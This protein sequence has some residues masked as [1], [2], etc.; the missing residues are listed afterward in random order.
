MLNTILLLIIGFVF[1]IKSADALVDGASLLAKHFGVSNL[2]IGLT[3]VAFGTSLPE[4][5]VNIS[6]SL[7]NNSSI[8]ISNIMGSNIINI[9]LILGLSAL[10]FPLK[11]QNS[12]IWKEIPLCLL[13]VFVIIVMANDQLF[14]LLPMGI[15]GS[16][17]I[18]L[19]CF[20]AVFLYY[21]L[22]MGAAKSAEENLPENISLRKSLALILIG[23]VGLPLGA[24]L[25]L[26]S[27]V[28]LATILHVSQTIIGLTI[29]ALGTSLPELFTSVS[30]ALKRNS[31]IAVGNIVGSNLF[32]TFFI[33]GISAIIH[34][35]A[36]DATI[37]R[38]M[39][40]LFISTLLFFVFMFTGGA[41]RLD[42][43]EGVVFL[44]GYL[45]YLIWLIFPLFN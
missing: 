16:E 23:V 38:D 42:R 34:P 45:G 3:V 14:G 6:A 28:R 4:L 26:S 33:L 20:F 44:L 27:A 5:F 37:N 24:Q 7:Q 25:T 29:V 18:L 12:T 8:A 22:N 21:S 10:I 31:D 11:V 30:A 9:L 41:K 35:I 2:V 19:L 39:L 32:N 43:W 36:L 40:V 1:L 15:S 17:G 13:S